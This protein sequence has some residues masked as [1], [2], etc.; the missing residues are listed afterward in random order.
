MATSTTGQLYLGPHDLAQR[1]TCNICS[2]DIGTPC[3]DSGTVRDDPHHS[4]WINYQRLI[5]ERP[6]TATVRQTAD[7]YTE[8][9]LLVC[10]TAL[11]GSHLDVLS[12]PPAGVERE[13]R[14]SNRF[15]RFQSFVDESAARNAL[16]HAGRTGRIR[17]A[18]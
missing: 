17:H 8:G 9:E 10:V 15:V 11:D 18:L 4:R 6:F 5:R 14:V 7:G 12:E 16:R 2:S 3:H 1:V 13:S